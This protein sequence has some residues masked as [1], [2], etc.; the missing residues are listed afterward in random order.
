MIAYRIF[1]WL[2]ITCLCV[3]ICSYGQP[4]TRSEKLLLDNGWR[5]HLGDIPFPVIRGNSESYNAS[6]AGNAGGAAAV[7]YDD[8]QWRVL[9]LP[10]DWAVESDVDSSANVAQGYRKRGFG[11]YRRSFTLDSTDKGKNLELQFEGIATHATVWVNGQVVRYSWSAYNSF[12]IDISAIARYGK[13]K[14]QIAVRVDADAMEGWWYEGAGIYR[15]T[16]LVK[17]PPLHISTDGVFA[18]PIKT[19]DG[20]WLIP[21]EVTLENTGNKS[22]APQVNIAVYDKYGKQVTSAQANATV[23]VLDKAV[24]KLNLHVNNPELWNIESPVLYTVKTV[25]TANGSNDQVTTKCGFRTI[26]FDADSGFYLNDKHVKIQGVC[27]HID[28][29]GVGTAM[30]DALWAFRIQKLKELGANGYRCSHN[31]PSSILL[32]LCDSLGMVVMDENRNFNTSPEYLAQL[33]WMVRRDRNHPAIVLWSVFNEEPIQGSPVGYEMVRRMSKIVKRLDTSRPVTAAM[34]GGFFEPVNV[35]QAVDVMGFNYEIK[36]Y[37]RFHK[38]HPT[39]PMT[40][41]EDASGVMVRGEYVTDKTKHTL[42]SYDTQ[43]PSWAAT[44]R[45]AWKAIAERQWMAGCFVWTGFDY[46]GEPTPYT[47]PTVNSNFGIMDICGF[48]KAAYYI[49]QSQWIPN[50]NVLHL[51][52]HWNWPADSIG[53][54]I[55]VMALSNADNVKLLLNGKLIGEKKNDLYEMV[56]WEVPYK[57]GKLEAIGYKNGKEVSRYVVETT[58]VPAQLQLIPYKDTLKNDGQD[59]T[60]ITVQVLDAAGRPVPTA[61][62]HITFE[63]KGAGNIIGLGNGNPNSHEPEKGNQQSL[64]NGL[65][66]VIVQS[67]P[68]A[69]GVLTITAK[70]EGLQPATISIPFKK[71]P[72][73]AA[74]Q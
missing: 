27:N 73:V 38:E 21:A 50:K 41:S 71:V 59:V 62:N 48:P 40:S 55:K 56:S 61:N 4:G 31:P 29:V 67:Q 44:H 70:A 33:E 60:P 68:G 72:A 57:P 32:D 53:K 63:I 52:P 3:C 5:F 18:Q 51:I 22:A 12:Y 14:N 36:G 2:F 7:K 46:H 23:D 35:S 19:A 6:K 1:P 37:D 26:R 34:S 66:Q 74:V 28:H 9:N 39:Q 10:H 20:S 15:H 47:W 25:V 64:F 11:W 43:F 16:W 30:P 24:V 58:G 54:P 8:S 17:R 69:E 42:D 13:E 49:H 45:V 65:A